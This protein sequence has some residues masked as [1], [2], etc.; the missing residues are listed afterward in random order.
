MDTNIQAGTT[1]PCL[2]AQQARSSKTKLQQRTGHK[3]ADMRSKT[4]AAA[5]ATAAVSHPPYTDGERSAMLAARMLDN[6]QAAERRRLEA[7]EAKRAR[8][9]ARNELVMTRLVRARNEAHALQEAAVHRASLL[10][11]TKQCAAAH[12]ALWQVS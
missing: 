5:A 11:S 2:P 3:L 4:A 8:L 1:P 9:A 10:N 7:R 6:M 12:Q